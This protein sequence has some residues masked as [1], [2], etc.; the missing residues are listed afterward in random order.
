MH[1]QRPP[2]AETKVVNCIR[3]EIFDVAVD[4]RRGSPTFLQWHGEV[5]SARNLRSLLIPEGCAHGFQALTEDCE[6]LIYLHTAPL[7]AIIGGGRQR[8]WIRSSR[9]RGP[10]HRRASRI[11]TPTSDA[12]GRLRRNPA[13]TCRHC[14][15]A[16]T[17]P[18]VDLGT[19]PPSNAYL[20]QRH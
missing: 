9:S 5:L 17:L 18:F 11:E 1:F 16:V 19:A 20:S 2:L 10:S 12:D 13:V 15:A 14:G 7:C 4:L 3:G 8:D 6:E